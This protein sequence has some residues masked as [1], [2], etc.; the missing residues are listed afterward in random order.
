ML[1]QINF[2]SRDLSHDI[3]TRYESPFRY[4]YLVS[5]YLA[6]HFH[7][8]SNNGYK[9]YRTRVG[10]S[11][12]EVPRRWYPRGPRTTDIRSSGP[13]RGPRRPRGTVNLHLSFLSSTNC[14]DN[15]DI[16][17]FR[18]KNTDSDKTNTFKFYTI[19]YH[20]DRR[21]LYASLMTSCHLTII[22]FL[23]CHWILIYRIRKVS[24]L[25]FLSA[26]L[27]VWAYE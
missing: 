4:W 17:A 13:W 24:S 7:Q 19:K 21:S 9:K 8:R 6:R 14:R 2:V 5:K 11:S 25:C 27:V 26:A 16:I 18:C 10:T 1:F 22:Y 12:H 3:S 15:V 23:S 20:I